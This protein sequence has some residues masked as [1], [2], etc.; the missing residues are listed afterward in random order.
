MVRRIIDSHKLSRDDGVVTEPI[1][2]E[3]AREVLSP[4]LDD[5]GACLRS[6]WKR[7]TTLLDADAELGVIISN[8][9]RA[10]LVYDF[11]RYDAVNTFDGAERVT[12]SE[13][14]GF[15]L[16]TFSDKIILRFK[17]FRDSKLRVSTSRSK[18]STDYAQQALP[19][20]EELT[21]L[22]AGYLPDESGLDLEKMAIT[23]SVDDERRWVID[24]TLTE[25]DD[26]DI[27]RDDDGDT[28]PAGTI[29]SIPPQMPP[30]TIVRPK[31]AS[32]DETAGDAANEEG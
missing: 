24:L 25:G 20:M 29:P 32:D 2:A 8:R 11:I 19:G 4:H 9:S 13:E 5:I 17:K 1:T 3:E 12:I 27:R 18:Q 26:I 6:G 22:V 31:P 16:L 21:H 23:C 10:A 30:G 28:G 7:W 14:R 15:L